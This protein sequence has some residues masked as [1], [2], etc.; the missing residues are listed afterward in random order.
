MRENTRSEIIET[1]DSRVI[2]IRISG[3]HKRD[4]MTILVDKLDQINGQYEK[5]KVEKLIPCI[6]NEC[7][8]REQPYFYKY[9]DL[10]RRMEKRKDTV[11][12]SIS[13]DNVNVKLL[14]DD[15]LPTKTNRSK[16]FI[17][18]SHQDQPYLEKVK[19][20]LKAMRHTGLSIEA[21]DDKQIKAGS[22]WRKVIDR[23]MAAT[24]IAIL[25]VSTNFFAS[26]FINDVE[27]PNF[28]NAAENDGVLILPLLIKPCEYQEHP[29]LKDYQ[30]VNSDLS[31]AL[32]ALG[33]A[34][35]D[36]ELVRLSQR[37]RAYFRE[38]GDFRDLEEGR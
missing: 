23:E 19:T 9:S 5:M 30:V 27:L 34:E 14:V 3:A 17:S 38:R 7:K 29:I 16:I 2:K 4:F 20:Q 31:R 12:C 24:K 35:Q 26:D 15:V 22:E 11:E 33:E 25:L 28:L 36:K 10:K 37:V 13:Y 6:C 8:G 18:Y 32:S 1:Y 21:F